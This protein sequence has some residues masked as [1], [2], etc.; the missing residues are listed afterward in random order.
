M[1]T[2]VHR[3]WQLGIARLFPSLLRQARQLWLFRL[4]CL[5]TATL[6]DASG[7]ADWQVVP[8]V[9]PRGGGVLI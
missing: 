3:H 7:G 2:T 9:V 1:V 8:R 6:H 5:H 4:F